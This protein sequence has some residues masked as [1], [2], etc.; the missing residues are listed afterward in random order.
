M[1]NQPPSR[2]DTTPFMT[3][4]AASVGLFAA[5]NF[6][7]RLASLN[8]L[9]SGTV[10]NAVIFP[11]SPTGTICVHSPVATHVADINDY[12]ALGTSSPSAGPP[13][14]IFYGNLLSRVASRQ[15]P[16]PRAV[17]PTLIRIVS[18]CSLPSVGCCRTTTRAGSIFAHGR[19]W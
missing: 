4:L 15:T 1:S 9:I 11:V 10:S 3:R 7:V 14:N 8:Y 16:R 13:E 19:S 17:P 18:E 2:R 6:A 12:F 5:S